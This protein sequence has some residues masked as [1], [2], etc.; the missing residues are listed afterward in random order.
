MRLKGKESGAVPMEQQGY[1]QEGIVVLSGQSSQT[2]NTE[3]Q[4]LNLINS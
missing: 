1:P 4:D 3:I 2:E